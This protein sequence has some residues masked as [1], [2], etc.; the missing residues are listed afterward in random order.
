MRKDLFT[1]HLWC[2]YLLRV[3]AIKNSTKTIFA[4]YYILFEMTSQENKA[5]K[6]NIIN[7][8][9]SCFYILIFLRLPIL[10]YLFINISRITKYNL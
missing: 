9:K 10:K 3:E 8:I 1:M 6:Y 7:E 5:S 2:F 4:L